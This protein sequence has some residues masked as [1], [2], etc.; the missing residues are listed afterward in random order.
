[1]HAAV[2]KSRCKS[3]ATTSN[4]VTKCCRARATLIARGYTPAQRAAVA[5]VGERSPRR[6]EFCPCPHASRHRP[7]CA[8]TPQPQQLDLDRLHRAEPWP[9]CHCTMPRRMRTLA[10][11]RRVCAAAAAS[12]NPTEEASVVCHLPKCQLFARMLRQLN[13][14]MGTRVLPD[15]G[16][17]RPPRLTLNVAVCSETQPRRLMLGGG[18]KKGSRGDGRAHG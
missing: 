11:A 12:A 1:M 4:A 18:A 8:R 3:H 13:P 5:F 17:L 6:A 7:R 10:A 2:V 16:F 14:R 9:R 15:F